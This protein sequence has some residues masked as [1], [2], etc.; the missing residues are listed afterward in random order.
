MVGEVDDALLDRMTDKTKI[1]TNGA[2]VR[3]MPNTAKK[4]DRPESPTRN[5]KKPKIHR[6]RKPIRHC[7]RQHVLGI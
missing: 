7:H 5:W 6:G 1:V 4:I 3:R 2:R